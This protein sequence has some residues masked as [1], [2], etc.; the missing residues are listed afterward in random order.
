MIRR[1]VSYELRG[2]VHQDR[3]VLRVQRLA[4]GGTI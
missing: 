4:G 1:S 2:S 3:R